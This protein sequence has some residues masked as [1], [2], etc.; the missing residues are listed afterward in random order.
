M[1]SKDGGL[2]AM[3]RP[4]MPTAQWSTIETGAVAG[5]VP[6]NEYCFAGGIQGWLELKQTHGWQVK[7]K[8]GQVAWIHRRYRLGG[9]VWIAVRRVVEAGPRRGKKVDELWLVPGRHVEVVSVFGL[10][11]VPVD[12]VHRWSGGPDNWRWEQVE[13]LLRS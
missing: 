10:P 5:G 12:A 13:E 4:R 6:D 8:P 1:G 11:G 3:L 7:F 2:R 9:R